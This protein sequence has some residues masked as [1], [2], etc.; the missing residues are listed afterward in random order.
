MRLATAS[1][2]RT[3]LDL[4]TPVPAFLPMPAMCLQWPAPSSSIPTPQPP[5]PP[6][7]PLHTPPLPPPTSPPRLVR[8]H[9]VNQRLH[10]GQ[11]LD[12][13]HVEA[14]H[15]VPKVNLLGLG[16]VPRVQGGGVLVR[17]VREGV[18]LGGVG[19]GAGW[20]AERA[21]K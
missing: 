16:H 13:R 8:L 7:L 12:A 14:V 18:G 3:R 9:N 11:P 4:L 17:R 10:N 1:R 19:W 15:L 21:G 20:V 2:C 6:P 5:P